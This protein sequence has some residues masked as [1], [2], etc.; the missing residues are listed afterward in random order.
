[1]KPSKLQ[2]AYYPQQRMYKTWQQMLFMDKM[3]M[4]IWQ[5]LL[6]SLSPRLISTKVLVAITWI[7]SF[8]KVFLDKKVADEAAKVKHRN[9]EMQQ[10]SS[11]PRRWRRHCKNSLTTS[12]AS[13]FQKWK[14]LLLPQCLNLIHVLRRWKLSY[15]NSFIMSQDMPECNQLKVN[16]NLP[17]MQLQWKLLYLFKLLL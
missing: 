1:M 7:N 4:V 12:M 5:L 2:H 13:Q 14:S 9:R 3:P 6:L 8:L 10:K 17:I 11:K 15:N 16:C